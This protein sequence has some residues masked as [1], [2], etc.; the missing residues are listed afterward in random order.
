[1]AAKKSKVFLLLATLLISL[2]IAGNSSIAK[3]NPS[4]SP[5]VLLI[6]SSGTPSI[7]ISK[8]SPESS[9]AVTCPTPEKE[10]M[11]TV[12]EKL[13]TELR[14]KK[15]TVR[16]AESH[17]IKHP[18]EILQARMVIIGSPSYFGNVSWPIK[19]FFD[20]LFGKIYASGSERLDGKRIAAFS[21]AEI[22]P[23]ARHTLETIQ[24]AV[25][26]CRGTFGPTM[27]V[28]TEHSEQD[29]IERVT[30]FAEQILSD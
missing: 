23:S 20:E 29:I 27:I 1:M 17:E 19:K 16:V 9:D 11:K 21:M 18:D 7:T 4:E 8:M 26:D 6:Y 3:E 12:S 2:S 5:D 13:G 10:N 25:S 14:S 15:L 22:E 24:R 30:E 28:L